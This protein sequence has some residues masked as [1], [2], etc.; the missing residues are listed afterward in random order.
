MR[1]L[2]PKEATLRLSP[3]SAANHVSSIDDYRQVG[4]TVRP[5]SK[6]TRQS[7]AF[8]FYSS[9]IAKERQHPNAY[10]ADTSGTVFGGSIGAQ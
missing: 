6:F 8:N 1:V 3:V 2:G 5:G 7:T 9:D 10:T 4:P